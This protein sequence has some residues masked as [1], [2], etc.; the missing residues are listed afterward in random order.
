[1]FLAALRV[2]NT[3]QE[4]FSFTCALHTYFAVGDISGAAVHG[5]QG[6]EYEDGLQPVGSPPVKEDSE[7]VVFQGEVDRVYG[8]TPSLLKITDKDNGRAISIAKTP[9]FPDAVVW[10]PW[11]EKTKSLAD[12]PDADFRKFVCVEVRPCCRT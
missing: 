4:P 8:P 11:V 6:C 1:M 3:G 5:L 2:K 10:N 7:E 9:A 12:M